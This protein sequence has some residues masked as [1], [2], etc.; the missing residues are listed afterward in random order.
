[1]FKELWILGKL[2]F[3][4]KPRE[5]S[6]LELLEMRHFPFSGYKFMSWC[7]KM[8]YRES[9]REKIQISMGSHYMG[10]ANPRSTS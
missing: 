5:I 4:S 7:G 1:M 3:S 2:L 6:E 10:T 8:I 9:N